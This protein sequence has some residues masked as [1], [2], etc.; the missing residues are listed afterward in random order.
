[1]KRM[2]CIFLAI[3]MILT[4]ITIPMSVGATDTFVG[5]YFE[6]DTIK[7]VFDANNPADIAQ[8]TTS[9]GSAVG[10]AILGGETYAY[11]TGTGS[12]GIPQILPG[13]PSASPIYVKLRLH[14]LSNSSSG[15]ALYIH[16]YSSQGKRANQTITDAEFGT[17]GFVSGDADSAGVDV[18]VKFNP[19]NADGFG[20]YVRRADDDGDWTTVNES[21]V[22][23]YTTAYN[24]LMLY[25]NLAVSSIV[26]YTKQ[27]PEFEAVNRAANAEEMGA[28]L[29][30]YADTFGVDLTK[31]DAVEDADAVYERLLDTVFYTAAEVVEAFD[32]AVEAQKI[33]EE[34]SGSGDMSD[35]CGGNDY[36][37]GD[38]IS[39]SF[40]ADK[41]SDI[42]GLTTSDGSAVIT[43]SYGGKTYAH[44][45]SGNLYVPIAPAVPDTEPIYV[46]LRVHAVKLEKFGAGTGLDVYT[47]NSGGKQIGGLYINDGDLGVSGLV[48]ADAN[49]AGVD[50]ILKLNPNTEDGYGF[51]VRR[52]D[53][54][55]EWITI[56]DAKAYKNNTVLQVVRLGYNLAVSEI[57]I[58]TKQA[59]EFAALNKAKSAEELAEVLST[60]AEEFGI[61]LR[62]LESVKNPHG[63]YE[64]M[65]GTAY[66]TAEEVVAAFDA[67][68]SAQKASEFNIDCSD[69]DI[70]TQQFDASDSEDV[71]QLTTSDGSN[72]IT[73]ILGGE[74]YAH[75]DST[76]SGAWLN[77][78][79]I[80]PA[81]PGDTPIYVKLRLHALSNAVAG[82]GIYMYTQNSQGKRATQTITDKEMGTTGMVSSDANKVGVDVIFKLNPNNEDGYGVYARPADSDGEWT[83]V[84]ESKTYAYTSAYTALQLYSNLAVSRVVVY[85]KI[86]PAVVAVNAA[87]KTD[88]EAVKAAIEAN[89]V[90]LGIDLT[91]LEGLNDLAVYAEFLGKTY[92]KPEEVA[93][94]FDA[95]VAIQKTLQNV[96]TDPEAVLAENDKIYFKE[97]FSEENSQILEY[98]EKS[99]VLADG[100]AYADGRTD[101]Y[102]PGIGSMAGKI[103]RVVFKPDSTASTMN[104]SLYDDEGNR[105]YRALLNLPAAW[106][107]AVTYVDADAK[108]VSVWYRNIDANGSWQS[109]EVMGINSTQQTR[110]GLLLITNG[111]VTYDEVVVYNGLYSD[112]AVTERGNTV[113]L[114]GKLF[115]GTIETETSRNAQ[116]IFASYHK[117]YG[118]VSVI[119]TAEARVVR[120]A[121][122][123]TVDKTY[124]YNSS[125]ETFG[126]MFWDSIDTGII[127]GEAY[128]YKTPNKLGD[129]ETSTQA[130]G[131]IVFAGYLNEVIVSGNTGEGNVGIPVS[132]S[133]ID[134]EGTVVAATQTTTNLKGAFEVNVG[135]DAG[136]LSSGT[137]TVKATCKDV[138]GTGTV[139]LSGKELNYNGIKSADDMVAEIQDYVDEE[140]I[141]L[142]NQDDT[143]A[144]DKFIEIKGGKAFANFFE[145]KTA[146]NE[147][148]SYTVKLNQLLNDLNAAVVAERWS[149]VM[150]LVKVEYRE[151]LELPTNPIKGVTNETELFKR[152]IKDDSGR[153]IVYETA[154]EIVDAFNDA[155]AAQKLAEKPKNNG[156]GSGGGGGYGFGAGIVKENVSSS[157]TV[158]EMIEEIKEGKLKDVS[159]VSWA[160]E[161]INALYYAGIVSGDG[162][163][164][165]HPGNC[166]KREEFLKMILLAAGIPLD[167]TGDLKF[168]DVDKDAWYFAY[169][170]TAYKAGIIKGMSE[171]EFGIGE[172]ITRADMAVMMNRVIDKCKVATESIRPAIIFDDYKLIPDY[173]R[174][175]IT[176]LY[177]AGLVEGTGDNMFTPGNTATKAEAAVAINRIL[178]LLNNQ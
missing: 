163:G 55:G 66:Y 110:K 121:K 48:S 21:K 37:E 150:N 120:P 98:V 111:G 74:T 59:P 36:V 44:A 142:F 134:S 91:Q 168:E 23:A 126:V 125:T 34:N 58:Y 149:D 178:Q 14:A 165:F 62:K 47:K 177:M 81:V 141:A 63:V 69:G 64:R 144:Y 8:L 5:D 135:I 156:G 70:I 96:V 89:A 20:V 143:T 112:Y 52:A 28:A 166:V 79:Q 169:V 33:E 65:L 100:K 114:D 4:V 138:S 172:N 146:V 32:A 116:F 7:Q 17:T 12:L 108:T 175:S 119:D 83:S 124:T 157:E 22:Y 92:E 155:L 46:K 6:G 39:Q 57:K 82:N 68:I 24:K 67:A 18:I 152:M 61:D 151:F 56:D 137:Y 29:S 161:S 113:E 84:N 43:T 42:A 105:Y 176:T 27:A 140:L 76:S 19:N 35:D 25:N 85:K 148:I 30:A 122:E 106:H 118:Y 97:S 13:V 45:T 40:D 54:D 77:M 50:I 2:F 31:L 9:D 162:S 90:D 73:S 160:E 99:F 86:D 153:F 117:Q 129:T 15:N 80:C 1:M 38:V 60:Y 51:Y 41:E 88:A 130:K 75:T 164:Y 139:E 10:T 133:I 174:T 127:L 173:A 132:V 11:T 158:E 159:S 123:E 109:L 103:T 107:E 93:Q 95:S 26:V 3:A 53:P 72:V 16:T 154:E 171:T 101:I 167:E 115:Y 102:V 147:A 128:G 71:A 104:I 145:F 131:E 49:D 94:A 136:S 170:N 87:T 78:P